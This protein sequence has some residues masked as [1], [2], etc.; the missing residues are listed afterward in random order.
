MNAKNTTKNVLAALIICVAMTTPF[1]AG[2]KTAGKAVHAKQSQPRLSSEYL[3]E[4]FK[5]LP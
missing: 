5:H 1:A 4:Y 2:F 3:V